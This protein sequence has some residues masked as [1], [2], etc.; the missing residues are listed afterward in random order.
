MSVA[1]RVLVSAALLTFVLFLVDWRGVLGALARGEWSWLGMAF[2]AFNCSTV[3]AAKRWQL[4]VSA[5]GASRTRLKMRAAVA[6][7]YVSLWLSNFLPTA[8]GGDI[9]RVLG[10]RRAGA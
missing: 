8:F 7:T 6:A 2:L 5:S 9:A 4:I 1:L 10:A 3:F